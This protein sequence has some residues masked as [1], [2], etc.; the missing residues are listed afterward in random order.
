MPFRLGALLRFCRVPLHRR[1]LD[2]GR[3]SIRHAAP[4]T[5]RQFRSASAVRGRGGQDPPSRFIEYLEDPAATE[6][7]IDVDGMFRT[8]DLARLA[9]TDFVYEAR[10]GDAIR[11]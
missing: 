3:G 7:A 2:R 10:I 6:R 11:L 8:G 5:L 4:W 1:G 9:G